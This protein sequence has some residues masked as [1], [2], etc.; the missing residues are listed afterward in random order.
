MCLGELPLVMEGQFY[1]GPASAVTL[2]KR[3]RGVSLRVIRKLQKNI[4]RRCGSLVE[5]LP[6]MQVA[7][8]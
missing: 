4:K 7:C 3:G 8:L 2:K 6:A 1:S 5:H